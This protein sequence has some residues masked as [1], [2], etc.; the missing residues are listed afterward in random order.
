VLQTAVLQRTLEKVAQA[1]VVVADDAHEAPAKVVA[2]RRQAHR[3]QAASIWK[4]DLHFQTQRNC[5]ACTPVDSA[6]G[7]ASAAAVALHTT[8]Q[9]ALCSAAVSCNAQGHAPRSRSISCL[10]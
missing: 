4:V 3:R 7:A 5:D 2:T 1:R 10:V 6:T 9:S 8:L